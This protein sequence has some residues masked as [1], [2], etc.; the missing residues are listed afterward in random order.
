KMYSSRHHNRGKAPMRVD[1][2][3]EVDA[4]ETRRIYQLQFGFEGM[5]VYYSFKERRA[6]TT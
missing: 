6:I 3:Q 1:T 2:P 4:R 5:E